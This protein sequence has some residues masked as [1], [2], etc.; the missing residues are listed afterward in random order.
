MDY[1]LRKWVISTQK[2]DSSSKLR[3]LKLDEG[4]TGDQIQLK[5]VKDWRSLT[6]PESKTSWKIPFM[7]PKEPKIV[8]GINYKPWLDGLNES[9]PFLGK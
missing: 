6:I 8:I 9:N 7:E 4:D 1:N 2:Y 5:K 3:L